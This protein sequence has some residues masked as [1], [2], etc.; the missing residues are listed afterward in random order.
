VVLLRFANVN[1][2][3]R[4]LHGCV[5]VESIFTIINLRHF[6]VNDNLHH[7][8]VY[9]MNDTQV[10]AQSAAL[11][12]S[13]FFAVVKEPLHLAMPAGRPSIKKEDVPSVLK[14]SNPVPLTVPPG[15]SERMSSALKQAW[16]TTTDAADWTWGGH[17]RRFQ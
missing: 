14:A 10:I 12:Y 2:T 1:E 6:L 7:F 4:W 3:V 8:D 5:S 16:D 11:I 9:R 15:W 17:Q 13:G